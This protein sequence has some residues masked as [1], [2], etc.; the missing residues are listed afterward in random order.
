MRMKLSLLPK[1]DYHSFLTPLRSSNLV[2]VFGDWP[3]EIYFEGPDSLFAL[4]WLPANDP[5][6]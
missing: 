3:M 1:N 5:R 6:K 2:V 4:R